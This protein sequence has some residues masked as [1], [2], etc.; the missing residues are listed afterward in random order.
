[1]A[2][3]SLSYTPFD[4]VLLCLYLCVSFDLL[5]CNHIWLS[6]GYEYLVQI[7]CE[8]FIENHLE[9]CR[10]VINI[11]LCYDYKMDCFYFFIISILNSLRLLISS[12]ID[13]ST[14]WYLT[15]LEIKCRFGLWRSLFLRLCSD[16]SILNWSL[17]KRC[18][19]GVEKA[20]F[21]E[22]EL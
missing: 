16:F 20:Y 15:S 12:N 17:R 14:N 5:E 11:I 2:C 9:C 3:N 6:I 7:C 8:N 10:F 18:Q 22:F 21:S 4:S 1:M 13:S 19:N